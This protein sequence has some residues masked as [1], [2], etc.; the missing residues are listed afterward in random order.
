[1][2]DANRQLP[3]LRHKCPTHH[4]YWITSAL[5]IL[6]VLVGCGPR[7][8]DLQAINYTP[9]RRDDWRIS[10]PSEQDLDPMRVA[11]L[12]Y[13][14][15]RLETIHSLLVIK[16]GHLVAEDYFNDGSI[17]RKD[18]LQ[19]V[20]KS[21]TS[22]LVGIALDHG[23]LLS[24]DQK[25][26][27]SYPEIAGQVTDPRKKQITIRQL[28]QM[29]AGYPN[30]E[31]HPDLWS[32]LLSGHYPPLIEHFPLVD[33]PGTRFHYSNLSSNWL[34]IIVDR[35]SGMNLKA[36]A[37]QVLFTPLGIEPGEWGQDAEGH[38]NGC[39]DLHLR[40]RDAAKFGLLYL[41]GGVYNG[42]QIISTD[43]V[44]DSLNT[45]S[46]NEAFVKKVG[47][48]HDIG[49]GLQW[50]SATVDEYPINFAWGHGGQLIVLLDK[51]DLMVVA[52]AHPFW[53]EH[54]NESWKHE[55]AMFKLVGKF[56]HSLSD[57]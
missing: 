21:F 4:I 46:V 23:I 33:D 39:G 12:Y 31:S 25:M 27:D 36:F 51:L 1:M 9:I 7:P 56:I 15:A 55:K 40:A 45:Y 50:W 47:D 41:D 38:N 42:N 53:L 14:A 17:D 57:E 49:Y 5:L 6:L 16:N 20:T 22:A 28:L 37:E 2:K 30:E 26:L 35:A 29:R 19:S 10:T 52:T 48:F 44:R 24:P 13:N 32:G 3:L 34:G 8:E 54:N 43:W 18:R 11:E